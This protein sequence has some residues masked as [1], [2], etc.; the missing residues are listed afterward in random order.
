MVTDT[1]RTVARAANL[2]MPRVEMAF[3]ALI[4]AAI[5]ATGPSF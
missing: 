1:I 5:A 2:T 4:V 3:F